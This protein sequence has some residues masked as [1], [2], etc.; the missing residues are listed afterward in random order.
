VTTRAKHPRLAEIDDFLEESRAV[1][2]SALSAIPE[3]RRGAR[4]DQGAWTASQVIE[5]L[6]LVEG[7]VAQLLERRAARAR[8]EGLGPDGEASSILGCIDEY[9]LENRTRRIEAPE[10]VRPRSD[11]DADAALASLGESRRALR[12]AMERVEGLD[13]GA[14]RARHPVLGELDLYQWLVMLGRHER[15]H[16]QQLEALRDALGAR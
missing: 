14:M 11:V 6:A 8:D 9:H 3:D 2:L 1:L 12:V 15:R 4:P 16:A 5:H 10:M 13:L 7:S